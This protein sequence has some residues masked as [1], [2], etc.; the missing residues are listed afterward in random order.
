MIILSNQ[1]NH[2]SFELD[3]QLDQGNGRILRW[4]VEGSREGV[5]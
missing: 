3:I 1:R 4:N 5:R 2:N